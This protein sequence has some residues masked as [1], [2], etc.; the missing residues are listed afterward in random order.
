VALSTFVAVTTSAAGVFGTILGQAIGAVL[1]SM[2][3]PGPLLG[4]KK[5]VPLP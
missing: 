2:Y 1:V 4:A 5:V 3:L